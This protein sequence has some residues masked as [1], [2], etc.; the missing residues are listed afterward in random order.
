MKTIFHRHPNYKKLDVYQQKR[1]DDLRCISCNG[2]VEV[3]SA[4]DIIDMGDHMGL[5]SLNYKADLFCC[6]CQEHLPEEYISHFCC[7]DSKGEEL[8]IQE[9]DDLPF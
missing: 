3:D 4:Y 7:L 1:H 9:D 6:G 2:E 5:G 8:D